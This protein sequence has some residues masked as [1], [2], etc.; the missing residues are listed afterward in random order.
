MLHLQQLFQIMVLYF[1][2]LNMKEIIILTFT[3]FLLLGCGK[4][5]H[6]NST[7]IGTEEDDIQEVEKPEQD[8]GSLSKDTVMIINTPYTVSSGDQILKSSDKAVVKIT[9]IDGQNQSNVVLIEGSATI[10]IKK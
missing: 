4:S 8:N 3:G 1:K 7:P 2:M 10:I 5:S 6:S 9:H